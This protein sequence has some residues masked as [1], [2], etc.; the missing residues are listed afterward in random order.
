MDY[1]NKQTLKREFAEL[2][3]E[4]EIPRDRNDSFEP[5]NVP[6]HKTRR[7]GV[8][9]MILKLK[10][11]GMTVPDIMGLLEDV[12][13]KLEMN[14]AAARLKGCIVPVLADLPLPD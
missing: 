12:P 4:I 14:D 3:I 5:Q 9:E 6:K 7:A 1:K 10:A 2:P 8:D 13:H 11:R